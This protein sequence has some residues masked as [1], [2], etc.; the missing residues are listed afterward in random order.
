M[1]VHW[2]GGLE[3]PHGVHQGLRRYAD[4]VDFESLRSRVTEV[5]GVGR[6]GADR[7]GEA[8]KRP[9]RGAVRTRARKFVGRAC[10]WDRR[11]SRQVLQVVGSAGQGRMVA[12]GVCGQ[13]GVKP[14]VVHR[15]RW[16]GWVHS[17]Q[18][19][20]ESGLYS[21]TVS[22][23]SLA[24]SRWRTITLGSSVAP[25]RLAMERRFRERLDELLADAEVYPC[26]LRGT[27]SRLETFLGS[28]TE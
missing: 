14:I 25:R 13:V 23:S 17:R 3:T 6:T 12:A 20:G 5:R 18:S 9:Q 8:S 21:S 24:V 1:V 16:S 10:A 7:R 4:L 15:W 26:L 22:Y 11:Q 2:R 19:P 28:F 27:L